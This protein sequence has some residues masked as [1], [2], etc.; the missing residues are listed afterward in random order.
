ML[1][2]FDIIACA[3]AIDS[4]QKSS[5]SELSSRF[6]GRKISLLPQRDL[7]VATERTLRGHREIS[8]WPQRDLSVATERP[9]RIFD[10]LFVR[11]GTV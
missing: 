8:L 9:S 5:K 1:N 3:D 6:F 4:V 10:D 2:I 11:K 7:S